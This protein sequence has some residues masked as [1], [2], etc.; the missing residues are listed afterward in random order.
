M[1]DRRDL[2]TAR[3]QLE[4]CRGDPHEFPDDEMYLRAIADQIKERLPAGKGFA[5]FMFD[6]GEG[7]SMTYLSNANRD[8]MVKAIQE[9]L[10]LQENPDAR[11]A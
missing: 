7:G 5:L 1:E 9:W 8:D 3:A 2:A 6:F 11:R 4:V 10:T